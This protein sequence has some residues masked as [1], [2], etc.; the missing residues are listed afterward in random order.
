MNCSQLE[1]TEPPSNLM[2]TLKVP[3]HIEVQLKANSNL[4]QNDA[5]DIVQ[6][7]LKTQCTVFRN[8]YISSALVESVS[9][10][11]E[12]IKICDLTSDISFWYRI[13]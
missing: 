13:N 2:D 4:R 6:K 9:Q 5:I 3:V 10:Q 12:S 11:I 8:G 1:D 7:F